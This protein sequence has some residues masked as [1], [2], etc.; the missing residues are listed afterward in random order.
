MRLLYALLRVLTYSVS[1]CS[2]FQVSQ[3]SRAAQM[4][5]PT[6]RTLRLAKPRPPATLLEEW[7][8]MPKPKPY[9][10]DYNR[11][12]QLA[13]EWT[14]ARMRVGG[15][16]RVRSPLLA[17]VCLACVLCLNPGA[18]PSCR[19]GCFDSLLCGSWIV[20]YQWQQP[21]GSKHSI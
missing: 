19:E 18:G 4:A 11:L 13:S 2:G 21:K 1:L 9:V 20:L 16:T 6:P 8:P 10:S 5:I 17:G 15:E 12:L 14:P 3:V 7:D